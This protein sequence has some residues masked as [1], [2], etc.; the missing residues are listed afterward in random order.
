MEQSWAKATR[1]RLVLRAET[2]Q[3]KSAL[4]EAADRSLGMVTRKL[5]NVFAPTVVVCLALSAASAQESVSVSGGFTS[6]SGVIL[7]NNTAYINGAPYC[8]DAGCNVAFGPATV[9]F[10]TPQ[11]SLD[12]FNKQGSFEDI[13]NLVQFTPAPAQSVSGKGV[14]F[15]LGTFTIANG[16]WSGDADFG[17]S[18]TTSSTT[19]NSPLDGQNKDPIR[20]LCYLRVRRGSDCQ[21]AI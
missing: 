9:T 19:P 14:P 1:E 17:F 8:P 15:L 18:L 7:G 13:H 12:F 20:G 16:V 5:F 4:L 2:E 6:F 11:L 10:L 3:R 21:E